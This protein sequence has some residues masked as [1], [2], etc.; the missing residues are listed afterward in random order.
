M[1]KSDDPAN[2]HSVQI[3]RKGLKKKK[4]TKKKKKQER[5]RPDCLDA[6]ITLPPVYHM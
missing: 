5:D 3:L 6:R 2:D 4:N 1:I